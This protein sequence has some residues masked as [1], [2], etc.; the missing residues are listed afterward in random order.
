[1]KSFYHLKGIVFSSL[2][3]A[4]LCVLSLVN[5][6]LGFTPVPISLE[7]FVVMLAGA[8][9]GAR[10]GFFSVTLVVILTALGLP[11]LHGQGGLSLILGPTG[12]FIWAFPFAAL[13]I[14]FFTPRIKGNGAVAFS[15]IFL[16]IFAFGSLL[17]Y[18]PGIPWLAHVGQ[19]TLHKSLLLGFYP[20]IPGDLIKAVV[21]TL[22]T[23]TFRK[24][25]P[26]GV[27]QTA[28]GQLPASFR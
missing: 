25:Y 6:P 5:I 26:Q 12:G 23:M 17:L 27:L 8:I 22:I 24:M 3:A 10:Y 15:L 18:I 2:F 21:A 11:L 20:Y 14:G 16:T 4:L 28:N 1:M 7:N 9:L 13:L 19:Y